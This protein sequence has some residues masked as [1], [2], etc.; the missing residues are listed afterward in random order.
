MVPSLE[1]S[2]NSNSKPVVPSLGSIGSNMWN[3]SSSSCEPVVLLELRTRGSPRTENPWSQDCEA[4][5]LVGTIISCSS[6][7]PVVPRLGSIHSNLWEPAV[8]RAGNLWLPRLWSI[9]SNVWERLAPTVEL[10][11]RGSKTGKHWFGPLGASNSSNWAAVVPRLGSIGSNVWERL[12]RTVELGNRGSKTGKHWFEPLGASS[13]SNWAAVVPRLG[14]IGSNQQFL[15]LGTHAPM[16]SNS[17]EPQ[18]Y[19]AIFFSSFYDAYFLV[20]GCRA[21]EHMW[22]V[23]F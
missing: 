8:P 1:T 14:S 21:S 9:G 6:W 2:G 10:G 17:W 3:I 4:L 23:F 15:E 5:V 12:A 22:H 7:K 20:F 11:N 18:F 19:K 16:T 13:S